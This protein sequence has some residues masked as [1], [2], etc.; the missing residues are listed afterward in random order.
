MED[1]L[2]PS[3]R[4]PNSFSIKGEVTDEFIQEIIL[5]NPLWTGHLM[6]FCQAQYNA[7]NLNFLVSVRLFQDSMAHDNFSWRTPW[8]EIDLLVFSDN[9]D[10]NL[11]WPSDIVDRNHIV[12]MMQQI[13]SL[14]LDD[15]AENNIC[16][17][18]DM[19]KRTIKRM[20]FVDLYGPNVF[21]ETAID[22][23]KTIKKD[24]IPRFQVS[25]YYK[26]MMENIRS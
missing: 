12:D 5:G 8:Q 20:M 10:I 23:M 9:A 13:Q 14:Y 4:K 7:E 24:I 18:V 1:E 15:D 21:A 11:S 17:S 16:I 6:E 2:V 26:D 22:P 3:F 25:S 19:Y